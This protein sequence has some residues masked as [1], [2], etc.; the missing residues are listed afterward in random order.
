MSDIAINESLISQA[1]QAAG[2]SLRSNRCA[3]GMSRAELGLKAGC[4]ATMIERIES[5]A[6]TPSTNWYRLTRANMDATTAAFA[7]LGIKT[8]AAWDALMT[9]CAS[10]KLPD[11]SIKIPDGR[12]ATMQQAHE[13]KVASASAANESSTT[14]PQ[15]PSILTAAEKREAAAWANE[16]ASSRHT[17]MV[18][19]LL[20][21]YLLTGPEAAVILRRIAGRK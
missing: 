14:P 20:G 21:E 16:T 10:T 2:H 7:A 15:Q 1:R 12:A 4:S 8:P 18:A 9:R 19:E 3:K 6:D 13:R 5:C 11:D 17:S